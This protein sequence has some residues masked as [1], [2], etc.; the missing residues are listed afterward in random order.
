MSRAEVIDTA[1]QSG[2]YLQSI[3]CYAVEDHIFAGGAHGAKGC[4]GSTDRNPG[5]GSL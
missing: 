5:P 3:E 2:D 4:V 1:E